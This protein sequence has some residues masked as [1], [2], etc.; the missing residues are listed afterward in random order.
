MQNFKI[1]KT[2]PNSSERGDKTVSK[3][4]FFETNKIV[5]TQPR[6]SFIALSIKRT[7]VAK[8]VSFSKSQKRMTFD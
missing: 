4:P 5:K 6:K 7:F 8:A 1:A 2:V 3:T